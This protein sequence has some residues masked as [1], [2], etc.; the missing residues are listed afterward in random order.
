MCMKMR[1][2][3]FERRQVA[4]RKR[5]S[6]ERTEAAQGL[7][8]LSNGFADMNVSKSENEE[9][10]PQQASLLPSSSS[11]QENLSENQSQRQVTE[12]CNF[13]G[14]EHIASL[15]VESQALR[16]QNF[17]LSDKLKKDFFQ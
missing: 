15:K 17:E 7:L 8:D 6:Q 14:K 13:Q 9:E 3:I 4:K 2:K 12:C 11:D 5:L 10:I 16:T 1:V